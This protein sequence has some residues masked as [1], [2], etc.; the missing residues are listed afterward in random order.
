MNYSNSA[1]WTG[2]VEMEMTGFDDNKKPIYVIVNQ[3]DKYDPTNPINLNASP[4]KKGFVAFLTAVMIIGFVLWTACAV[5]RDHFPSELQQ[6]AAYF[7][8]PPVVETNI[9]MVWQH[10]ASGYGAT[11]AL[12]AS[13]LMSVGMFFVAIDRFLAGMSLMALP[14]IEGLSWLAVPCFVA[15]GL[16]RFFTWFGTKN[17]QN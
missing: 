2:H 11:M 15:W 16:M 7:V 6:Y 3:P 14:Y 5:T 12:L 1:N 8:A 10:V 4:N 9:S 13:S 17:K